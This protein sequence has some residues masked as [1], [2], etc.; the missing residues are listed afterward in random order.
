MGNFTPIDYSK[1]NGSV[2]TEKKSKI[3]QLPNIMLVLSLVMF[4]LSL[5]FALQ[6]NT[7]TTQSQASMPKITQ[8]TGSQIAQE[9]PLINSTSQN[10]ALLNSI[11]IAYKG[12]PISTSLLDDAKKTLA[13][14]SSPEAD[15]RLTN[16]LVKFYAYA[17][18]LDENKLSYAESKKTNE[19]DKLE[20][21][22]ISMEKEIEKSLLSRVDFSYI[23]SK[24]STSQF[25]NTSKILEDYKTALSVPD[26]KIDAIIAKAKTDAVLTEFNGIATT[27]TLQDFLFDNSTFKDSSFNTFVFAQKEKVVSEI[28]ILKGDNGQDA[29][30]LIYPKI[31]KQTEYKQ[32]SDIINSKISLFSTK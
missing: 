9:T 17:D 18:A 28:F 30:I 31:V 20:E 32:L 21:D 16:Q 1:F 2:V 12:I 10:T 3:A 14:V 5:T 27:G 4:S 23:L 6:T 8:K 24:S 26:A 7:T 25:T 22:V 13:T 11:P 15:I 19:F 29:L